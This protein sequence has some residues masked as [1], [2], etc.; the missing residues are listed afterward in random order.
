M[1]ISTI[2]R[3]IVTGKYDNMKE[4]ADLTSYKGFRLMIRTVSVDAI[5]V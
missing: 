2:Q 3:Y 5:T 4:Y 1:K